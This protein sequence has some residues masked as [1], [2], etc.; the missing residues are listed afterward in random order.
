MAA[1]RAAAR[2]PSAVIMIDIP[3]SGESVQAQPTKSVA[4]RRRSPVFE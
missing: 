2:E 1:A 4:A 3:V